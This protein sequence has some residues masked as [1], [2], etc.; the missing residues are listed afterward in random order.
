[1]VI[2]SNIKTRIPPIAYKSTTLP[3]SP[4]QILI[5]SNFLF[6][7][8]SSSVSFS[9]LFS[10]SAALCFSHSTIIALASALG[11]V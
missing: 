5:S 10:S 4:F 7:P 2:I 3:F 11:S 6:N 9:L 8:P 1:M